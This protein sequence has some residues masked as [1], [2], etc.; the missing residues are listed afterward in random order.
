MRYARSLNFNAVV[1]LFDRS[2][3]L[4]DRSGRF[5]NARSL[6]EHLLFDT[7]DIAVYLVN[8]A[9]GFAHIRCKLVS[10]CLHY[11]GIFT[12]RFYGVTDFFYRL[13][14]VCRKFG[15]FVVAGDFQSDGQI[16]VPFRNI[17]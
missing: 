13:I 15:Y 16:A 2:D 14:E 7:V 11:T 10:G 5:G 12:D 4:F 1:Q 8:S 17:F 3:N 9:C 6:S